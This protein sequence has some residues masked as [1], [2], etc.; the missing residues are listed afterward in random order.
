MSSSVALGGPSPSIVDSFQDN[1]QKEKSKSKLWTLAAGAMGL[2]AA[3]YA[4]I[5]G[6]SQPVSMLD[7]GIQAIQRCPAAKQL[8]DSNLERGPFTVQYGK[9]LSAFLD[10]EGRKIII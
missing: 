1:N 6:N 5:P 3:I 2:V 7:R 4:S 10:A 9:A 8:W